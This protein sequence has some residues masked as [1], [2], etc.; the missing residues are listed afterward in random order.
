MTPPTDSEMTDD[1]IKLCLSEMRTRVSDQV[2]RWD[3][4]K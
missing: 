1:E 2:S 4:E 3:K